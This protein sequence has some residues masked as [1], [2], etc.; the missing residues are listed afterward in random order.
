MEAPGSDERSAERALRSMRRAL[1]ALAGIALA[2]SAAVVLLLVQRRPLDPYELIELA[3][4]D[5]EI[6]AAAIAELVEGG[7]GVWD[8][9]ADPDVGRILQPRREGEFGGVQVSSNALGMREGP[10]QATKP[11]GVTRVVLL[12]DSFVFGYEIDQQDRLGVFLRRYLSERAADTAAEIECLHVAISSWNV[13]AE[14]AYV[15]RQLGALRPDLVVQVVVVN[16]LDDLKGVRGFGGMGFYSPQVRERADGLVSGLSYPALWPR[17]V[18]TY[19]L[20]GLDH[21]SRERYARAGRDIGRLARTVEESGGRYLLLGAWE[22]YNP[23]VQ[24]HLAAELTRDQVAFVSSAFTRDLRY[25]IDETNRHWNRAGHEKMA[26]LLYGLIVRRELLPGLGLE[27]WDEATATVREIHR[28][29]LAEALLV[30]EYELA[31]RLKA[32][33]QI[34]PAF[35]LVELEQKA[36]KQVHGGIDDEG[37]VAPYAALILARGTGSTLRVRGMRLPGPGLEGGT[38]RVQVEEFPLGTIALDGA[39]EIDET[40]PLPEGVAGREYLTVRFVADD[41][42]YTNVRTGSCAAFVLRRVAIE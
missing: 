30:E 2:L 28:P 19:L 34:A 26:A 29:G 16:D 5:P 41:Y 40:W 7:R 27:P 1:A 17:R 18:P 15:R 24:K 12:G 21:E 11:A 39:E 13:Q 37:R 36:V 22:T 31:L 10:Y 9:F 35:D 6:R 8:S 14:C 20:Y 42:V 32:R 38:A 3:K 33:G 23:M 4:S 25:R